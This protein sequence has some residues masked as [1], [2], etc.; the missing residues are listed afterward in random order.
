[1]GSYNLCFFPSPRS[2]SIKYSHA[3]ETDGS[4]LLVVCDVALGKCVDLFKK[5][6][7]LT[8]A[9]P[10]YDS[11]HGVSKTASVPTD[12][13]VFYFGRHA[14]PG[15][16]VSSLALAEH[17]RTNR[18]IGQTNNNQKKTKQPKWAP[19]VRPPAPEIWFYFY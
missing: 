1:M 18:I 9:P 11:V 5:D 3:G 8:E 14:D 7:S 6:F 2:T 19:Q 4:R 10:G 13:E 15:L 16:W 12:F 17:L